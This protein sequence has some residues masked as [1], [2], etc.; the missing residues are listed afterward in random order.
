MVPIESENSLTSPSLVPPTIRQFCRTLRFDRIRERRSR[1]TA[2]TS[3]VALFESCSLRHAK[4]ATT[5]MAAPRPVVVA[6]T[7]SSDVNDLFGVCARGF[8]FLAGPT[9]GGSGFGSGRSR[10]LTCPFISAQGIPHKES[11]SKSSN[12]PR[13]MIKHVS[14]LSSVTAFLPSSS[15]TTPD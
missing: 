1:A 5:Q 14:G 9:L 6:P 13:E 15:S 8:A 10:S 3:P 7:P 11:D 2:W 4:T 12:D